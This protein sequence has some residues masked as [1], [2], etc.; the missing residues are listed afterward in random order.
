MRSEIDAALAAL[1]TALAQARNVPM[2]ASVMVHREELDALIDRL[3]RAIDRTL[4]EAT[5]VVGDRDAVIAQ[6]AEEA[7]RLL[8]EAQ[9]ARD[10]MLSDTDVFKLAQLQAAEILTDARQEASE[11]RA[12]TDAYIEERL[13]NFE[14]SLEK[15]LE[16]VRRGRARLSG[17]HVHGLADDSDVAAIELPA[18][19]ER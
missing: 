3:D 11:L 18:H 13:A 1:R 4:D 2:S 16:V 6:S 7:D 19:L 10:A 12:E 8:W 17:G 5:S 14:L 15:T 9:Q